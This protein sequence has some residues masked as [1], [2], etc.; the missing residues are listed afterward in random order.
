VKSPW[1]LLV[2]LIPATAVARS[3][4]VERILQGPGP[5]KVPADYLP[6]ITREVEIALRKAGYT[7]GGRGGEVWKGRLSVQTKRYA[8][9]RVFHLVLERHDASGK[10]LRAG[11]KFAEL[12]YEYAHR[13]KCPDVE[14][15]KSIYCGTQ[16]LR[17]IA[18]WLVRWIL[19]PPSGPEPVPGPVRV[20]RPKVEVPGMVYV[21]AGEFVMGG[22]FGEFDEAPRH[23]VYLD[24]FYIDRHEV[25]NEEYGRC[26]RAGRCRPSAAA[27]DRRFNGPRQ[28]VVSISWHDARDYCR[29]AGQKRLP[30]EAEWEKAARGTD[31]RRYPWG[32]EFR[33]ECVNLRSDVD[34]YR[35]TAPVGSF[36]CGASPY[37]ALD[38][39]GNA[40]E[41]CEDWWDGSY[42]AVSPARN[43]RGPRRSP[44]GR[45]CMRGGTWK[46]EVA[47]FVAT[48]NRSHTFPT[49]RTP[50][51]GFRCA[52][53]EAEV[54]RDRRRRASRIVRPPGGRGSPPRSCSAGP[55]CPWE[56]RRWRR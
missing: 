44:R 54:L 13:M 42:Y 2:A 48:T 3:A 47:F 1:L 21:P 46:Y 24:A 31:E 7:V 45:R 23:R 51:V 11:D 19:A 33:R 35:Y 38:M 4:R 29:F 56:G 43:P 55:W 41:W 6:K 27:R 37:G 32:N 9:G 20:E 12:H 50:W 25:T 15:A 49:K 10:L 36:P 8:P 34:G 30:T 16:H 28:P 39:A 22:D 40:W 17:Y 26:V 53:S 5:E 18:R 52:K 14:R